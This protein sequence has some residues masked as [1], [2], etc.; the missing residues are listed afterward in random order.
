M[1][2]LLVPS[3]CAAAPA[4]QRLAV[5]RSPRLHE[6]L[7][8]QHSYG[9]PGAPRPF[10]SKYPSASEEHL[11]YWLGRCTA[12]TACATFLAKHVLSPDTFLTLTGL[13]RAGLKQARLS[14]LAL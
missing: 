12:D 8:P 7:A 3:G 14:S 4:A 2:N 9:L 11:N 10:Y 1:R 13:R 6:N 5:P